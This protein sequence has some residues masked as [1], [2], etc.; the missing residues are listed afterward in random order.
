MTHTV[1]F[2][3]HSKEKY[4]L[5]VFQMCHS[6]LGG[7]SRVA[8]RIANA[9]ARQGHTSH[10][11]SSR[12]VEWEL[13]CN[14]NQHSIVG[15]KKTSSTALH[16][17]WSEDEKQ[18]FAEYISEQLIRE[19]ADVVHYHYALPFADI[20]NRVSDLLGTAMPACVGT[21]HG[22]DLMQHFDALIACDRNPFATTDIMVTVSSAMKQTY[23]QFLPNGPSV[24]VLPNFIEDDWPHN[25]QTLEATQTSVKCARAKTQRPVL[26]HVSNFQSVKDVGLLQALVTEISSLLD[27]ELWLVGEG[28]ELN[29]LREGLKSSGLS[30]VTTFWGKHVDPAPFFNNSDLYLST[31]KNEGFG[32]AVL[33]AMA[34]GVPSAVTPV[35]GVVEIV[36]EGKNAIFI[37]TD[38]LKGTAQEIV[39][40]LTSPKRK[41][42]MQSQCL[43]MAKGYRENRVIGQYE[44]LYRRAMNARTRPRI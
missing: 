8:C 35:G 9:M 13:H 21:L 25:P 43:T 32:L 28:Q 14:V 30:A 2:G 26:L 40:L 41:R 24:D 18:R 27:V 19:G 17:R 12:N 7:S 29:T 3:N 23:H 16:W 44:T 31:S 39:T 38:D 4:M 10:V 6:S 42:A 37:N 33:E 36:E 34:S 11:I 5:N 15:Q 20:I 22:T 1:N